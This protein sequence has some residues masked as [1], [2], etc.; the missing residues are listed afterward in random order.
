MWGSNLLHLLLQSNSSQY[1]SLSRRQIYCHNVNN[2]FAGPANTR[3]KYQTWFRCARWLYHNTTNFK[4]IFLGKQI[5]TNTKL[6]WFITPYQAENGS[7][8]IIFHHLRIWTTVYSLILYLSTSHLFI[9][10]WRPLNLV[11]NEELRKSEANSLCNHK[12]TS[13]KMKCVEEHSSSLSAGIAVEYLK[14][15]CRVVSVV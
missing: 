9:T 13:C 4:Q 15:K 10:R 11:K 8:L 3:M 2:Y 1:I 5:K 12:K 14:L 6:T 7:C